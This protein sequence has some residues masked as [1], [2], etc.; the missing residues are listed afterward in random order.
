MGNITT[1]RLHASSVIGIT[2]IMKIDPFLM[3]IFQ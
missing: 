2:T 3:E 1:V